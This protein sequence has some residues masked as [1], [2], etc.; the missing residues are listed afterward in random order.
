MALT[1]MKERLDVMCPVAKLASLGTRIDALITL[2]TDLTSRSAEVK[3][4]G[5]ELRRIDLNHCTNAAGLA[6]GSGS[7]K[8]ILIANTVNYVIGG[9]FKT[10]T[11]AEIDFTATTHDIT[12]ATGSV[13]EA[14]YLLSLAANGTCTVTKGTTATGAGNAVVPDC[15]ADTVPIGYL[16]LAVAAGSTN[17]DAT[18]DDLDAGHLTD[19]YVDIPFQMAATAT[20]ITAISAA[21]VDALP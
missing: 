8:K 4:L 13:Q 11:T 15:P 21:A 5:D 20:D 18:S 16:R 14:C 9:V 3:A 1:G 6:I 7:K 19:T 2:I 17:F 10:K 12:A